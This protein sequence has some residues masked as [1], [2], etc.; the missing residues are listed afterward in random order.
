MVFI[1]VEQSS[2]TGTDC[3]GLFLV[4]SFPDN[5]EGFQQCDQYSNMLEEL[6]FWMCKCEFPQSMVT[7]LLGLLPDDIYKV[8]LGGSV[9]LR[10]LKFIQS[11]KY[12][13]VEVSSLGARSLST[14]YT[15]CWHVALPVTHSYMY[16]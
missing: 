4:I 14:M 5:K 15:L 7:L 6:V 11:T 13:L 9:K 12:S 3:S 1:R 10:G 2:A 8:R 16:L